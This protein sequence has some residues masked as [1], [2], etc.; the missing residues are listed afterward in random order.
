M[1]E[2]RLYEQYQSVR[3]LNP[4]RLVHQLQQVQLVLLN[5]PAYQQALQL[6]FLAKYRLLELPLP[7]L[8]LQLAQLLLILQATVD[9]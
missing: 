2:L 4:L 6:E 3:I 9:I 1:H 8:A 5:Q 7:A